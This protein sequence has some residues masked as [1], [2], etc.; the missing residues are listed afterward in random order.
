MK[1]LI[2]TLEEVGDI[3][4]KMNDKK[5]GLEFSAISCLTK[6]FHWKL[7]KRETEATFRLVFCWVFPFKELSLLH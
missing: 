5:L 6:Q 2:T 7:I 3:L 1:E 4:Q